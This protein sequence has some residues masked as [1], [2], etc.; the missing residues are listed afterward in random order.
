MMDENA[1]LRSDIVPSPDEVNQSGKVEED[2]NATKLKD[3]G[4]W[5]RQIYDAID[6]D[7]LMSDHNNDQN[8]QTDRDR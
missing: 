5:T 6:F 8:G 4:N 2:A 1:L 3:D 7:T